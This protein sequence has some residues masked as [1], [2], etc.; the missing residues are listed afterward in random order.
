MLYINQAN[1]IALR[2]I[3]LRRSANAPTSPPQTKKKESADT[4]EVLS[5]TSTPS[6]MRACVRALRSRTDGD[7]THAR[8]HTT[9]QPSTVRFG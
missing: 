4:D 9:R 3:E 8:T 1:E 7:S 2:Q 5:S 6:A